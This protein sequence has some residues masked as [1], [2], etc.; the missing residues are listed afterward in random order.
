MPA[1]KWELL[2]QLL[3]KCYIYKIHKIFTSVLIDDIMLFSQVFLLICFSEL[4]KS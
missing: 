2:K 3:Q 1:Q 4:K